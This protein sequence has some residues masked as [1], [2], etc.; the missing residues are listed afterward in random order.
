MNGVVDSKGNEVMR[1]L[2]KDERAWLAQ[3]YQET[4]HVDFKKNREL[5]REQK[6]L[7]KLYTE[8]L[9]YKK[10]NK[11]DHPEVQAQRAKVEVLRS[12]CN[13]FYVDEKSRRELYT[14]DNQRRND[15]YNVMKITGQLD[16]F[17][18]KE[19][20]AFTSEGVP[21]GTEDEYEED[22]F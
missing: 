9:Q 19:F 6:K 10:D 1:P 5:T 11:D 22:E 17:D 18:S 3:Y 21:V 8:H 16:Y 7:R 12:E 13:S 4:E 14:R 2:T 15:V 20:D